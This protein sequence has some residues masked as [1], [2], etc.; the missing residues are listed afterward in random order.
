MGDLTSH[1]DRSEVTCECGCG[2]DTIDLDLVRIV[3]QSRVVTKI[4]YHITSGCRCKKHNKDIGGADNSA[5]LPYTDC[6]CH[7]LDIACANSHEMY[8]IGS[9]LITRFK[10]LEFGKTKRGSLWIHVD[11]R[12][13]LPQEVLIINK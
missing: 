1:F 13:D 3:E 8:I 6:L 12:T 9:D 5:H 4:P 10:R 2:L 11:N 7:A